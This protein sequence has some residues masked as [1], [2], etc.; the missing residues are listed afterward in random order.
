MKR[1]LALLVAGMLASPAAADLTCG[2]W[3]IG[4]H[5]R[6]GRFWVA[7]VHECF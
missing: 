4:G 6:Y 7:G 2:R 1:F 3:P 5:Y